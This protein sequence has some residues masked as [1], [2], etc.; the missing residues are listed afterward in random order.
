M[1]AGVAV[2]HGD[3]AGKRKKKK[4]CRA[5]ATR[6]GKKQCCQPNQNCVDRQCQAA[7]PAPP[8]PFTAVR[9]NANL[10]ANVSGHRRFAQPFVAGGDG[11]I[12]KASFV[13]VNIAANTPLGVQ[14]R[15]TQN[16][17]PTQQVLGTAILMDIEPVTAGADVPREVTAALHPAVTVTQGTT[18]ALVITDLA[19]NG[20]QLAGSAPGA[21]PLR[22]FIDASDT[23]TFEPYD[24]AVSLIFSVGP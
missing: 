23:N 8:I 12:T 15:T 19:N 7:A 14:I 21:C 4:K 20:V 13:L 5:P 2:P 10:D 11:K 1:A 24:P 9:C 17:V 6:C 18:Y 16:G 3:A 22:C